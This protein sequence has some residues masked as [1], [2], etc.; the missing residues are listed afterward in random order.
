MDL[1]TLY[2]SSERQSLPA[3]SGERP[4]PTESPTELIKIAKMLPDFRVSAT[5]IHT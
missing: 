5:I 3:S 4:P 1:D 2:E